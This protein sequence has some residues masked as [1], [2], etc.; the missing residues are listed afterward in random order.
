MQCPHSRFPPSTRAPA[1]AGK[2]AYR[3][4]ISPQTLFNVYLRPWRAYAAAGGRGAMVS[5][6]ET[7]GIP[8]HMSAYLQTTVWR[9]MFGA[10]TTFLA[11]DASDVSHLPAF[12][13]AVNCTDAA[14]LALTAGLDQELVNTCYPTLNTS[15]AGGLVSEGYVDRAVA[16]LL[17]NKFATGLF[18]GYAQ[19][20]ASAL[21]NLDAPAHRALAYTAAAEGA[22]LLQN[23]GGLLPLSVG[24][25]GKV[26]RVAIIGP[27]AGCVDPN[28][29]TCDAISAQQGGYTN[30]GA[31]VVTVRAA[32][33]AGAAAGG[34]T[35][36]FARGANIDDGNVTMI[37]A[38]VAAAQGA[39]VAV[40]VLGDSSDGYGAGSC[41]EGIDAD[42]L[43]LV[44]GQ[45]ALLS[46]LATQTTTPI[47]LVGIH[48]RPFTLG[49][50]PSA[51]TG[52]NNALLGKVGAVL[53]AWRPGEEGGN[54][55]WD[56][57]TGKVSVRR[58]E[59]GRLLA[60][61]AVAAWPRR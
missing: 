48:G 29:P 19:V 49:S 27:N 2:D 51:F 35:T 21:A 50:G 53:A 38:A 22:V 12:G 44:G 4:D 39:D 59:R 14:I 33:E 46:A 55:V 41:A 40:V 34:Y 30:G 6:Q 18:D 36:V 15:V 7:N 60:T 28:A 57:L 47:V 9:D 20:N 25:G 54:A 37:P 58:G 17:R 3:V 26:K 52:A 43:D 23:A 11:S 1:Q 5:H 56:I 61:P 24:A 10:T 42:S 45:L 8:N 32:I 13:M 31:P 16:N